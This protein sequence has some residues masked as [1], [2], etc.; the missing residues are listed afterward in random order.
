MPARRLRAGI[1]EIFLFAAVAPAAPLA[2]ADA[3][4]P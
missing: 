3:H 1:A 4:L 2:A